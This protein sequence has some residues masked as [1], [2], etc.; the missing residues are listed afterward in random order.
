MKRTI[1]LRGIAGVTIS[2]AWQV[3]ISARTAA[4]RIGGAVILQDT[5]AEVTRPQGSDF[6]YLNF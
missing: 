3:P 4:G 1:S 6:Y 2:L 5:V